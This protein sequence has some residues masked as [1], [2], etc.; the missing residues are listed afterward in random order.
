MFV[1]NRQKSAAIR[2]I[3]PTSLQSFVDLRRCIL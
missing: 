1:D 2:D 3:A